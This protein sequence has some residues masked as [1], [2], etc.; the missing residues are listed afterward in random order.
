MKLKGNLLRLQLNDQRDG[1]QPTLSSSSTTDTA[2]AVIVP[3]SSWVKFDVS[4]VIIRDELAK[5]QKLSERGIGTVQRT[6]EHSRLCVEG[7]ELVSEQNSTSVRTEEG[8]NYFAL[9]NDHLELICMP[10]ESSK[11]EECPQLFKPA[12]H[13]STEIS[14][15]GT[16]SLTFCPGFCGDSF[17]DSESLYSNFTSVECSRLS[18]DEQL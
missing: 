16:V 11:I 10:H 1:S 17:K 8:R 4:N 5:C 3:I 13:S 9:R 15:K 14:L 12:S 6:I 7:D 2:T 18:R